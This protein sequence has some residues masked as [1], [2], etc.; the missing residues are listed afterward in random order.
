MLTVI[1]YRDVKRNHYYITDDAKVFEKISRRKDGLIDISN[2]IRRH[3]TS[4]YWQITLLT[5]E[6]KHKTYPLYRLVIASFQGDKKD[7]V[8]DHLDMNKDNNNLSNLEYVT[9]R[10]NFR[11]AAVMQERSYSG[12]L[13]EQDIRNICKLLEKNYNATK[14]IEELNMPKNDASMCTVVDIANRTRWASISKDYNWDID[15]VRLKVYAKEDLHLIAYM[16]LYSGYGPKEIAEHF[17]K[18]DLKK[19]NH[20]V[21]KMSQG[22]L[23]KKFLEEASS[24]TIAEGMDPPRDSDGFMR[25]M[26]TALGVKRLRKIRQGLENKS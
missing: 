25:L 26:P 23:Y 3:P 15:D 11:R 16:L 4:G 10:E 24:T 8:V 13:S 7:M 21:K 17:P 6:G 5:K 9:L 12:T 2:T 14:I 18:Y 20:V 19:L 22:K 1:N